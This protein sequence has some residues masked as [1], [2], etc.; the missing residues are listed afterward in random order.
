M[1]L[2]FKSIERTVRWI[3]FL[4]MLH[5][6][7][8]VGFAE[9]VI[10]SSGFL[11]ETTFNGKYSQQKLHKFQATITDDGKWAF[12]VNPI[13][14]TNDILFG[15]KDV[16][17]M[18]F[19]GTDIYYCQYTEAVEGLRNGRPGIVNTRPIADQPQLA[20]I[21]AGDYPFSPFDNDRQ[22]FKFYGLFTALEDTYT[23]Q[24]SKQCL[25]LGGLP[26]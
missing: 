26:A 21:S 25:C 19:D 5:S 3:A 18:T 8:V 23:T 9:K 22:R 2:Y 16:K 20:Y 1:K 13:H 4:L 17:Y 14:K 6:S 12:E 7:V 10:V 24:K 15:K 11:N